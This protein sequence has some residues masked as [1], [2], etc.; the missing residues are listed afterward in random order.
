MSTFI[1]KAM[2]RKG[3]LV[4]KEMEAA[5]EKDLR[6]RLERQGVLVRS[7]R[8]KKALSPIPL[9]GKVR[10]ADF[11]QMGQELAA[12]L[13]AGLSLPGSLELVSERPGQRTLSLALKKVL[14]DVRDGVSFPDACARSPKVFD[15]LFVASLK[16][17][18]KAGNWVPPLLKYLE[19]LSAREEL[20]AKV[21]QA[22]TYPLFLLAVL[23]G[24][25]SVLFLFVL[26]RFVSIYGDFHAQLPWPTR[27][28]M[29]SLHHWP[30]VAGVLVLGTAGIWGALRAWR[31]TARGREMSDK[32][33]LALPGI[34]G[35]DRLYLSAVLSRTLS[36]LLAGGTPLSEAMR[37][38]EGALPNKD[39]ARR[40]SKARDLVLEGRPLAEAF[41]EGGLLDRSALKLL[42]AG[43]ASGQL[44][45][46]LGEIA[47][48]QERELERKV[49]K[50]LVLVE[51]LFILLTGLLIGAIIIVMYLPILHLSDIVR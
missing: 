24:I 39:F 10:Q 20:R 6:R 16:T 29:G 22:M 51:P 7:V 43:E 14:E 36:A 50:A 26:P 18:E 25:L 2:T 32:V 8:A 46:M 40:F 42:E 15:P 13:K 11:L 9:S 34:G 21:L 23:G 27:L 44:D 5:D 28:L 12:L 35:V 1:Y 45:A 41:R 47:R 38:A 3:T 30:W 4:T 31:S 49:G 19:H 37:T 17:G 48:I 33:R